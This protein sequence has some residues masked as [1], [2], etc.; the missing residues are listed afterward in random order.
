MNRAALVRPARHRR[1]VAGDRRVDCA[2]PGVNAAGHALA[3]RQ[4][5]IPQPFHDLEAA[6]AM[7]AENDQRRVH[8][9]EDLQL[10]WNGSHGDQPSAV[11]VADRVFFSLPDVDE[12]QGLTG[13]KPLLDIGGRNFE[14]QTHVFDSS[15]AGKR[16][17]VLATRGGRR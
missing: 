6:D 5:L 9:F 2:A 11:D 13:V 14:G 4:T 1:S 7:V 12:R 8:L 10:L 15:I 16:H 3:L 17:G